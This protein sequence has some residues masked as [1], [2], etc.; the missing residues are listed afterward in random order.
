MIDDDVKEQFE[1]QGRRLDRVEG[2]LG[3]LRV[4]VKNLDTR[5]ARVEQFLPSVSTKAD[6]ERFATKED[7]ERYATKQDLERFATKQDLERFATK[8]D[9][10]RYATKVDLAAAI[11]PLATKVEVREEGERTR[12]HMDVVAEHLLDRIGLLYEGHARQ[13]ERL[14]QHAARLDAVDARHDALDRRVTV[15]EADG[16]KRQK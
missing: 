6:L 15:L 3:G 16:A 11:A 5:L 9:L 7:L 14:D 1:I 10:E 4:E 2:E 8:Q 13:T 12:R